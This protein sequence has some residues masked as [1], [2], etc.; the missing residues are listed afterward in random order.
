V[1]RPTLT[2][3]IDPGTTYLVNKMAM[4]AYDG[5]HDLMKWLMP[6]MSQTTLRDTLN[7]VL[8]EKVSAQGKELASDIAHRN[9]YARLFTPSIVQQL[10][11][12][13]QH[14]FEVFCLALKDRHFTIPTSNDRISSM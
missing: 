14:R 12:P 2:G 1:Q 5:Y 7:G 3:L 9:C 4:F 8:D 10:T 11:A 13:F 6:M